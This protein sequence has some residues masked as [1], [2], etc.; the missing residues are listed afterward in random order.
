MLR[1]RFRT[2]QL[3]AVGLVFFLLICAQVK[4][5]EGG[6]EDARPDPA[7]EKAETPK[8]AVEAGDTEKPADDAPASEPAEKPEAEPPAE[9]PEA[10]PSAEKPEAK[11]PAEVS[12]PAKPEPTPT[13]G[14]DAKFTEW[15]E[16]LKQLRQLR[17]DYGTAEPSQAADIERRWSALI[18]KGETLIPEL[19]ETG[20]QEYAAAPNENDELADFLVKLVA[21][22]V[23]R[24]N[25][26]SALELAGLLLDNGCENKELYEPAGMAAF[27]VND[28]DKA[29]EYLQKA[30]DEDAIGDTGKPFLEKMDEFEGN[31]KDEQDLRQ[32]EAEADD[33]PRVR[34][35]TTKGDIVVELFEN[36]APD[37]VGNFVSLVEQ[38]FYNGLTFH[39]V[40]RG[41]MAQGGCPKGDGTA[42]PGYEIYCECSKPNHRNH[43]RGSLSMAHSGPNTGGSQFFLTF[44]PT[45]HLDGRH[46]VFGRVIE[47]M[48]VVGDL[49]L[50]NPDDAGAKPQPDK[51]VEAK[52]VRKREHEYK[53]NKS[54]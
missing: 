28:F 11:T 34:L 39:R 46:T 53:P 50:I 18:A 16:L 54:K 42:G 3:L 37:T 1:D 41:F 5:Q 22:D 4:A 30:K 31:W 10:K 27:G 52:V 36:E 13:A 32:K 6:G 19:R 2:V 15:K 49:Q 12:T 51:I 9:K 45:P 23:N 24:D 26:E 47:G 29:K 43:F 44:R 40:L 25:C 7:A 8:P 20:K 38:G 14:F 35:T 33:L 21:D 48:D 17:V